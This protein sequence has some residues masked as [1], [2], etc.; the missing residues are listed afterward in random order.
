[1][2]KLSFVLASVV[3]GMTGISSAS[4]A[5]QTLFPGLIGKS[6]LEA[7]RRLLSQGSVPIDDEKIQ[8]SRGLDNCSIESD[9]CKLPE[10]SS[11][12]VDQPLCLMEWHDKGG[13]R[14][15]VQT[16]YSADVSISGLKVVAIFRP[17]SPL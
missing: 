15:T 6:Y 12:A 8:E 2:K 16:S 5:T 7:K 13:R 9:I 17:D 10:V 14:F 4:S 11:C 1:M 3:V